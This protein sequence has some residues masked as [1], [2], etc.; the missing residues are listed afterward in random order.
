MGHTQDYRKTLGLDIR[1][2]GFGYL[3]DLFSV[4]D[5]AAKQCCK[6]LARRLANTDPFPL[7]IHNRLRY[8]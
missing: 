2:L 6:R 5:I 1:V 7:K 4:L 3:S 8:P